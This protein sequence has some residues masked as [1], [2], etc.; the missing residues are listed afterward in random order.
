M[1]Q[2][3]KLFL[4][5]C[6]AIMLFSCSQPKEKKAKIHEWV[7]TT[8]NT[9][10]SGSFLYYYILFGPSNSYYTYTSTV[11]MNSFTGVQW[12]ETSTLPSITQSIPE[13][14]T[15][16]EPLANLPDEIQVEMEASPGQTLED[17]PA[18]NDSESGDSDDGN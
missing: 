14:S 11:Q 5:L 6:L 8:T 1:K 9:D 10:G 13:N 12:T 16:E 4:H 3:I 15:I 17:E 7:T 2:T 18:D